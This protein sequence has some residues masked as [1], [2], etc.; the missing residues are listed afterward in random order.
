MQRDIMLVLLFAGM[1]F[2]FLSNFDLFGAV[3][4]FFRM[5]MSGLV[6]TGA[7]L[8]PIHLFACILYYT[9]NEG[10]EGTN[11]KIAAASGLYTIFLIICE[12][13]TGAVE[14]STQGDLPGMWDR[15]ANGHTGGGIIG[16]IL[17][18]ILYSTVKLPGTVMVLIAL[19]IICIV[20]LT[21][22]SILN[23]V[24]GAADNARERAQV[25]REEEAR[26]REEHPEDYEDEYDE[27]AEQARYD[28]MERERQERLAA[29]HEKER[30]RVEE[31]YQRAQQPR[32]ARHEGLREKIYRGIVGDTDLTKDPY[33][34]PQNPEMDPELQ[35]MQNTGAAE[36]YPS[37]YPMA[38]DQGEDQSPVSAYAD[39]EYVTGT[40]ANEPSYEEPS[41]EA[42]SYEETTST[43]KAY[44]DSKDEKEE[45]PP[46]SAGLELIRSQKEGSDGIKLTT[47]D[48]EKV[49]GWSRGFE[50]SPV[51]EKPSAIPIHR[52]SASLHEINI[53]EFEGSY[54]ALAR[55]AKV[56]DYDSEDL[57]SMIIREGMADAFGEETGSFKTPVMAGGAA[58]AAA[59]AF[60]S[61]NSFREIGSANEG[62]EKPVETVYE[63]VRH[64]T[65]AYATSTDYTANAGEAVPYVAPS[66]NVKPYQAPA[67]EAPAYE[68]PAEAYASQEANHADPAN[69]GNATA[70]HANAGYEEQAYE[71]QREE[72]QTP[73]G[74]TELTPDTS[75]EIPEIDE[76]SDTI[77]AEE[78]KI[79]MEA[80]ITPDPAENF[81][82]PGEA[83]SAAAAKHAADAAIHSDH[84]DENGNAIS[85]AQ[86]P[87]HSIQERPVAQA[88][89]VQKAAPAPQKREYVFPPLNLL[90]P[91]KPSDD[92][93]SD[94]ELRHTA[95]VLETTLH[96]FGVSC[97]ITDISQGPAV[98]RYELL[99]EQ[100]VKVSKVVGLQD[101]I[102]LAIAATD[103]RIEAPIPGKSAIGIE[104]PN[105]VTSVVALHDVLASNDFRSSKS[106]LTMGIGKD[107]SGSI[108]TSDLAKMPHVLIAGAT[109]SGKS[110]CINTIIMSILYHSAPEDVKLL[111]I[112]PKVVELSIYNGIP[113]LLY[114]VVTDPQRAATLLNWGV[115]EMEARYRKFADEHVRDIKGYNA[116]VQ[117]NLDKG[118]TEDA[119]GNT[120][121]KMP[122]IVIIVDELADLMMVA[123]S[124]VETAICRLAQLARACGIHL[125]IATQRPSVNVITGLIK[126][127]MPSRIAFAVT[128]GVD[129]RT[130]LDM[131]G[132]E[133]LLGKGDMLFFPQ[134][135][136]KPARIQGAFVSDDDVSAV[137]E[138]LREQNPSETDKEVARQIENAGSSGSSDAGS[139]GG[140]GGGDTGS[141]IDG[142][143]VKAGH[144]IIEKDNAS[145]GLLQR[146]FRIGFNRAARIMDQLCD[147]GVVAESEGTKS[148]RILMT[149][150]EFEAYCS[151]NDIT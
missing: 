140:N 79:A 34:N 82:H 84:H 35:N 150:M 137:V 98:T 97:K 93:G 122:R 92:S 56:P 73:P 105:K 149:D 110:V 135:L 42:P 12:I 88:A 59:S 16:G 8:F 114:P 127:N 111:M 5:L 87:A 6:G 15:C 119:D 144:F 113:H 134:G 23:I 37:S 11:A 45:E 142:L 63:T 52:E 74:M 123:K 33:L 47:H 143:F 54:A 58:S 32:D 43:E 64:E 46:I 95:E 83:V 75:W 66:V 40:S 38:E 125:I 91:G 107:I 145:I 146:A 112:D 124:D 48:T 26:W 101:D 22:R 4:G 25:R 80:P 129:S 18:F 139:V 68:A 65:A 120:Y 99:P 104:V 121:R 27:E 1:V 57:T 13:I 126:A 28:A 136:P 19:T 132:A 51:E 39:E 7:Y 62:A 151:E 21:Q 108:V 148:R 36:D 67:Y 49:K 109:G 24:E 89:P 103:I 2:L 29:L 100:G 133:K 81:V 85:G 3:G 115:S 96:T 17:G 147:A 86:A 128:Q 90:T 14:A 53:S 131:N 69:V 9:M 141:D 130:I 10:E 102:K 61:S 138:F 41:Y 78:T 70:V 72:P 77:E 71:A 94:E 31:R 118:I 106:M 44:D 116:K 20:F 117:E 76:A 50:D 60:A 30:R 55:D